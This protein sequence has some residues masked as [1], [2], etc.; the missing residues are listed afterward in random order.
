MSRPPITFHV[1][2]TSVGTPGVGIRVELEQN[3]SADHSNLEFEPL[4]NTI[5]NDDG[6]ATES[7]VPD[8]MKVIFSCYVIV[9]CNI[10]ISPSHPEFTV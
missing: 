2:D 8:G 1:L 9:V 7:V 5:T 4:G 10:C 6:R 3:V